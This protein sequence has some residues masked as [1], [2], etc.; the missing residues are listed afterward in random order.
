MNSDKKSLPK[1]IVIEDLEK[2]KD[3]ILLDACLEKEKI[4]CRMYMRKLI[5]KKD[6][7]YVIDTFPLWVKLH[8][9]LPHAPLLN[10]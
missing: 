3:D 6:N 7:D 9:Q 5:N 2:S 10:V 8:P 1:S 4:A